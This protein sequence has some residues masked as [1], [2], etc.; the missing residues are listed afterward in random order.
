MKGLKKDA[1]YQITF[2]EFHRWNGEYPAL[3]LPVFLIQDALRQKTLGVDWWFSKLSKYQNVRTKMVRE[4]D[5]T[6]DLV[7]IEIQRFKDDE[8]KKVRMQQRDFDIKNEQ[9][10]VRKTI[11]QARQ[12]LDE[13]T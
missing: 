5:N 9:S 10:E 7:A 12:F 8:T 4:G 1:D 6:D 2:E 3:Y 11:L 13:V